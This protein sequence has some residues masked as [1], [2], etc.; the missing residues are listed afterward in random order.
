MASMGVCVGLSSVDPSSEWWFLVDYNHD[1]TVDG[2]DLSQLTA[3]G[4]WGEST[5]TCTLT[6]NNVD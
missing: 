1:G 3:F 4:V 5:S 2:R 6:C